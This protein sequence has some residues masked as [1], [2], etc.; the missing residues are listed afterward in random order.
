[1]KR[2]KITCTVLLFFIVGISITATAQSKKGPV[3]SFTS[4]SVTVNLGAGFGTDYKNDFSGSSAF[5]TKVALEFGLWP[6]GPGVISLGPEAGISVSDQGKY[7]KDDF[8]ARTFVI[9]CRSAWHYGWKI[10]GLDTYAGLSAGA[11]FYH[12]QYYDGN[13]KDYNDAFPVVGGF[14]GVSYFFTPSFGVNAEA[15]FDITSLQGGLI[16]KLK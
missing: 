11:G 12:Y 13:H 9:A 1:M 6:A 15:G 10:S 4:G 8:R 5:G 3:G 7:Y 2:Q 14:A 16:F